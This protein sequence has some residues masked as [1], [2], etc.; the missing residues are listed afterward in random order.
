MADNVKVKAPTKRENF[1]GIRQFLEDNGKSEW[2]EVMAHEIELLERKVSKGNP[3]KTAE[4]NEVIEKI[5]DVLFENV[6]NPMRVSEM[7]KYPTLADYTSQ[8]LSA[9]LSKMVESGDV[10]KTVDKKVTYFSIA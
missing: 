2:A 7:L 9:M 4:Q 6:G 10:T 5:K 8:K 3:V 1:E